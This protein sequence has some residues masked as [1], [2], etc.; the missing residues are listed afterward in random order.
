MPYS[1]SHLIGV[2][3]SPTE[4]T[5]VGFL[6]DGILERKFIY[7]SVAKNAT[8]ELGLCHSGAVFI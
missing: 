4:I 7:I 8:L 5:V 3:Y 1:H 2:Q 6:V